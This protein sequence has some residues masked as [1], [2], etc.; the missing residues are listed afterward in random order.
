MKFDVKADTAVFVDGKI[1]TVTAGE[2]ET[3]D[4]GLIEALS[5]AKGVVKITPK[6]K[7]KPEP[8]QE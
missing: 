7:P 4:K 8:D 2:F 1:K 6:A 3:T 5:K